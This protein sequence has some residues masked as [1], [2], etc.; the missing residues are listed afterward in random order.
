MKPIIPHKYDIG[1]IVHNCNLDALA[2]LEP[3]CNTIYIKDEMGVLESN[4]L[5]LEQKHT[6]IKLE[7]KIKSIDKDIPDNDIVIEFDATKLNQESFF[8][9]TQFPDI[10]TQSGEEG[11]FEL[12]IFNVSIVNMETHEHELIHIYNK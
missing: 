3:W 6:L 1:F 4:Y 2:V 10:I 11:E 12:D 5:D 7:S 8:T 9:L